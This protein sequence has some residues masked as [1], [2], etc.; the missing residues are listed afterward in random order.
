MKKLTWNSN[1]YRI[2]N[3]TTKILNSRNTS[4]FP[5]VLYKNNYKKWKKVLNVT[6]DVEN[7]IPE[8]TQNRNESV[9]KLKTVYLG[10][11]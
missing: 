6:H 3:T 8:F 1:I 10:S 7:K 9:G 4:R 11:L 5:Y 2:K